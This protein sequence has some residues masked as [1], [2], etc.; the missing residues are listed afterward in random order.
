MKWSYKEIL[1][2]DYD[3]FRLCQYIPEFATVVFETVVFFA[4]VLLVFLDLIQCKDSK[5]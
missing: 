1:F 4:A 2:H 3:P 5:V